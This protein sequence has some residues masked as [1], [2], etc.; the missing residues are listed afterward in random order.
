[1]YD[2]KESVTFGSKLLVVS[3]VS[4]LGSTLVVLISVYCSL[5]GGELG[6]SKFLLVTIFSRVYDFRAEL[7]GATGGGKSPELVD[8]I[9]LVEIYEF[10]ETPGAFW[11]SA[12]FCTTEGF[13]TSAS[14]GAGEGFGTSTGFSAGGFGTGDALDA[15]DSDASNFDL[16]DDLAPPRSNAA[17]SSAKLAVFSVG[18]LGSKRFLVVRTFSRL[19]D[20]R[21]EEA[22]GFRYEGPDD[23]DPEPLLAE[24]V[25]AVGVLD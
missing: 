22:V 19:Y 6:S 18:E 15:F 17:L 2:L 12:G 10:F 4:T 7:V 16:R 8:V 25:A 1:M 21:E 20:L 11:T 3:L 5:A 9:E 13:G 14:F 23:S 24:V